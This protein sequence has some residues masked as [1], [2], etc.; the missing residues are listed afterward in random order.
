V[1]NSWS[2]HTWAD[3]SSDTV[4]STQVVRTGYKFGL[5][6]VRD[7]LIDVSL[8]QISLPPA[9]EL[10]TIF[11]SGTADSGLVSTDSTRGWRSVL[12]FHPDVFNTK[13]FHAPCLPTIYVTNGSRKRRPSASQ[14][15]TD[16]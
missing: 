2:F 12:A 6:A 16:T 5:V 3:F 9:Y 4:H 13:D 15:P 8:E 7:Y 11:Y 1:L 10:E 14:I